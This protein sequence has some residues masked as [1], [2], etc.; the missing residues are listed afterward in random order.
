MRGGHL[1]STEKRSARTP[2]VVP[3]RRRKRA[4]RAAATEERCARRPVLAGGTVP[5]LGVEERLQLDLLRALSPAERDA[6]PT[7]GR[8]MAGGNRA[9]ATATK[10]NKLLIFE[11]TITAF[12]FPPRG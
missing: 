7:V 4:A 6:L 9:Q 10:F 1:G 12:P 3:V 5:V 11:S 8:S 2:F